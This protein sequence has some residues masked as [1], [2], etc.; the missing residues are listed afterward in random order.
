MLYLWLKAGHLIFMVSWF[1]GI[2]YLPRIFVNLAMTTNDETYKHLLIMATKLYRF[3]SPFM[4]L[5]ILLG[6]WMLYLN[7][8]LLNTGWMIVKL[9]LVSSLVV[10]HF[11][12]GNYLK[13]FEQQ[14]SKHGHVFYRWFNEY[15]VIVLFTVIILAIIKP[16]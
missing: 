7:S 2:F 12:C 10:Y 4:W 6:G 9:L 8:A 14:T 5:T 11:I 16:F 1:A 15:P 13:T 3:I